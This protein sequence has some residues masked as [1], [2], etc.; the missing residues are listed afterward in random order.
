MTR[1]ARLS[2]PLVPLLL[3]AVG[4]SAEAQRTVVPKSRCGKHTKPVGNS[5]ACNNSVSY[6]RCERMESTSK[7]LNAGAPDFESFLELDIENCKDEPLPVRKKYKV[8]WR[9]E[10]YYSGDILRYAGD[11]GWQPVK[12]TLRWRV[13]WSTDHDLGPATRVYETTVPACH[14]HDFEDGVEFRYG[15]VAEMEH[16]Y[17][18]VYSVAESRAGLRCDYPGV[19]HGFVRGERYSNAG[20]S[21][22]EIEAIVQVAQ[23]IGGGTE[24]CE[25]P[26]FE[27]EP[28]PRPE[29]PRPV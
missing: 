17:W 4:N 22:S 15:V 10:E 14:T 7:L 29:E 19:D 11:G 8:L 26:C 6:K 2:L 18:A 24:P 1:G 9:D 13:G 27:P 28:P 3:F 21:T 16:Q 5:P 25:A 23:I 20:V 12:D